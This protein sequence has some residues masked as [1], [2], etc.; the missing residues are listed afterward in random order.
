MSILQL[1]RRPAKTAAELR[2]VL[3]EIDMPA[4]ER[5][6]T[7]AEAARRARLLD[8][9]DDAVRR[10]EAVVDRARLERDRGAAAREELLVR[11]AAAEQREAEQQLTAERD[12]VAAVA[13]KL[14]SELKS[15]YVAAAGALV[16]LLVELREAEAAVLRINERLHDAGRAAE[17]IAP[18]ERTV[19]GDAPYRGAP[20]HADSHLSVLARTKLRPFL[21]EDGNPD[22]NMPQ[23]PV[24]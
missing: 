24:D 5:R 16:E 23:W 13:D 22:R 2:A 11:I 21:Q 6:V 19:F 8:A 20:A 4:L 9:D 17:A 3:A 18:I 15:R 14:A 1:F 10:A 12:C 7:D